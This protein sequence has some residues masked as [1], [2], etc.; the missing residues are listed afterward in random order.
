MSN[1]PK[2]PC[3]C[4]DNPSIPKEQPCDCLG[5]LPATE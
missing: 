2:K 1:C 3:G 5:T 4:I